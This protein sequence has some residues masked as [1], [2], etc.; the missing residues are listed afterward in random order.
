M[1]TCLN[2][3]NTSRESQGSHGTNLASIKAD[4]SSRESSLQEIQ[5][6]IQQATLQGT[7]DMGR[8]KN[9]IQDTSN[10]LESTIIAEIQE[11]SSQ[12]FEKFQKLEQSSIESSSRQ[13]EDMK[14]LVRVAHD[15]YDLVNVAKDSYI[16]NI[17]QRVVQTPSLCKAVCDEFGQSQSQQIALC[18][19]YRTK[20]PSRK[21]NQLR[22]RC[23]QRRKAISIWPFHRYWNPLKA[24]NHVF[25]TSITHDTTCPEFSHPSNSKEVGIRAPYCG[26]L[27]ACAVR[28]SLTVSWG[29][30]GL[31]I[32]PTILFCPIVPSNSGAFALIE[33][34]ESKRGFFRSPIRSKCRIFE[35]LLQ[36]SRELFKNGRASPYDVNEHGETILHVCKTSKYSFIL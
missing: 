5:A 24:I 16:K 32:S 19:S 1:W 27:L 28:F 12:L 31:A 18:Q 15:V 20:N 21:F 14:S 10:H 33:S 30:G 36:E 29:A 2:L 8:L 3:Q 11:A 7:S 13:I 23:Q 4:F 34:I 22:C 6:N 26:Y 9:H 35:K 25:F 17:Q